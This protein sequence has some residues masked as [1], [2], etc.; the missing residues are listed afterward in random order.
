LPKGK[1]TASN[2][3]H[4]VLLV[5]GVEQAIHVEA[6]AGTWPDG[7]IRSLLVQ[8]PY[9]VSTVIRLRAAHHG[10]S[11]TRSTTDLPKTT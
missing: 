2:I 10:S 7:S 3:A 1:L 6:L 8:F 5:A 9:I 4:V 11:V